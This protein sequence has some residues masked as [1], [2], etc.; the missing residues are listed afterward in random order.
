MDAAAIE[1]RVR[2][3]QP[4]PNAYTSLGAQRLTIFKAVAETIDNFSSDSAGRIINA[5]RDDLRVS[6]GN[7][8]VLRVLELQLEGSRRM[9]VRDFLNGKHAVVGVRL[10]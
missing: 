6:C 10:G 7:G 4:W 3:F 5:H 9:G 8:T 1:R 2:G